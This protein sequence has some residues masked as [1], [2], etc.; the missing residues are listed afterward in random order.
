MEK[1]RNNLYLRGT[2]VVSCYWQCPLANHLWRC[3][4]E[5]VL[6]CKDKLVLM[7]GLGLGFLAPTHHFDRGP[8]TTWKPIT[9]FM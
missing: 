9:G 5:V 4:P 8:N 6:G 3:T 2:M 1:T 7:T